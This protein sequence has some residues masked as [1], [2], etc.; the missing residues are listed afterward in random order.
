MKTKI[1][2]L[3][4]LFS[5][6]GILNITNANVDVTNAST[7][8]YD[9][10][11]A[12]G[13]LHTDFSLGGHH[14]YKRDYKI[15]NPGVIEIADSNHTTVSKNSNISID[16]CNFVPTSCN[17]T[18]NGNWEYLTGSDIDY[19]TILI[20]TDLAILKT[21]NTI[22]ID[23]KSHGN[24]SSLKITYGGNTYDFS[25]DNV[26]IDMQNNKIILDVNGDKQTIYSFTNNVYAS[27]NEF[28]YSV[29][30]DNKTIILK[31]KSFKRVNTGTTKSTASMNTF[32]AYAGTNLG[33]TLSSNKNARGPGYTTGLNFWDYTQDYYTTTKVNVYP[34]N[35]NCSLTEYSDGKTN[36]LNSESFNGTL[37]GISQS[38]FSG[39]NMKI[40][41]LAADKMFADSNVNIAGIY[42]Q[43]VGE[44]GGVKDKVNQVT[45][46]I[47][48]DEFTKW[49]STINIP[50]KGI[51]D[52]DFGNLAFVLKDKTSTCSDGTEA[53]CLTTTSI[54]S[55]NYGMEIIFKYNGNNIGALASGLLI[56]ANN[57]Y[58]KI[59]AI[60]SITSGGTYANNSDNYNLCQNITDSYGNTYANLGNIDVNI[61]GNGFYLDQINNSGEGLDI[62]NNTFN[63]SK[64]CFNVKSYS[65]GSKNLV[66]NA[67][68]PTYNIN[69][70]ISG[71][72]QISFIQNI[73][74]NKPFTGDLS[75]TNAS[76]K[77]EIGPS[78][79]ALL[80][81]SQK[82]S[83]STYSINDFSSSFKLAD[84]TNHE[85][86]TG[87][88][89]VSS[90]N[91]LK[92]NFTIDAITN[93]GVNI[94]PSISI[95][96]E[97]SYVLDGKN[98][99]YNLNST[100]NP[101]DLNKIFLSGTAGISGIKVVGTSQ[102]T[103]KATTTNNIVN[104]SDLSKSTM[105]STIKRN[106]S[107]ITKG[108][109]E[110]KVNNGVEYFNG[111]KKLSQISNLSSV[112]TL[113]IKNGNLIIDQNISKS[114]FGII[115]TRDDNSKINIGN[116]YII[117]GVTYISAVIYSDG[118]V[119]SANDSG[120]PYSSDTDT[121]TNDLSKQLLIKGS[122]FTRNTIGGAVKG[123]TGK[124]ILPGGASTSDFNQAMMYD[125]NYVRRSND[126]W[127]L[128]KILNNN[129]SNNV[130]IIYNSSIQI[131][132]PI[133]F[134]SN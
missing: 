86:T 66:F 2:I 53:S 47:K 132:P 118:G 120:I 125:L 127:D 104:F 45:L 102:T 130:V 97:I 112:E 35:I 33:F 72:K 51:S 105:R 128:N 4:F 68:V 22:N 64:I 71:H 15:D 75:I 74:F 95:N 43:V 52:R 12:G 23:G 32:E 110:G 27:Q 116:V 1:H 93:A 113:I 84:T 122:L 20:E 42:Y 81:I 30:S 19:K 41:G 62:Y 37:A 94:A 24:G 59:G 114:K 44:I 123:S 63:N 117:P 115:V 65:P 31:R 16:G 87:P 58:T 7:F 111:D 13:I 89:L 82:S 28:Y 119:I 96:P 80:S 17:I 76:K 103:G 77:L 25:G 46:T 131:N 38:V 9:C 3:L 8:R 126:G 121:R 108:L 18:A 11:A 90:T 34:V 92:Y 79:N 57:D 61:S 5:F 21:D 91:N 98:I 29:S 124:Y 14:H 109:I 39:D 129:N 107:I 78:L 56:K 100:I 85:F 6:F 101:L 88:S 106:A 134:S 133:G 26:S 10:T 73:I 83:L 69:G 60:N 50:T 67:I 40:N 48:K 99:K 55:D 70:D 49:V 54:P 36:E